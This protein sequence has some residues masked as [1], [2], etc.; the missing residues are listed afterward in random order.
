MKKIMY[1]AAENSEIGGRTSYIKYIQ[2][3]TII[4]ISV[5]ISFLTHCTEIDHL[6]DSKN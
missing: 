1:L 6:E 5:E 4:L 3:N 2:L